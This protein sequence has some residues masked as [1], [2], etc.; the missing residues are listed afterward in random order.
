M[1]K[2]K[3]VDPQITDAV[4]SEAVGAEKDF[5]PE[6]KYQEFLNKLIANSPGYE[7]ATLEVLARLEMNKSE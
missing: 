3:A 6:A 4:T 7:L 2:A 1:A 5:S